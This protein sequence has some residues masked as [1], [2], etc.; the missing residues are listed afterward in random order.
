M[1]IIIAGICSVS[2]IVFL[3]N[4]YNT[5][6]QMAK[7]NFNNFKLVEGVVRSDTNLPIENTNAPK[8]IIGKETVISSKHYHTH[9]TIIHPIHDDNNII[10]GFPISN[11]YQIWEKD[12]TSR[13]FVDHIYLTILELVIGQLV[14]L[15]YLCF[16]NQLF[17]R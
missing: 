8:D 15:V 3:A 2:S 1:D 16:F 9:H 14:L 7:Q 11:T 4:D 13:Q 12:S 17:G 6:K 10:I 5:R